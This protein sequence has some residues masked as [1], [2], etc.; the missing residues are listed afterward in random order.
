MLAESAKSQNNRNNSM[1]ISNQ[2]PR[3]SRGFGRFTTQN[4]HRISGCGNRRWW[5]AW[6]DSSGVL[7]RKVPALETNGL[8]S[9]MPCNAKLNSRKATWDS[10]TPSPKVAS[11]QSPN[12]RRTT[13]SISRIRAGIPGTSKRPSNGSI[14]SSLLPRLGR[15]QILPR[16]GSRRRLRRSPRSVIS[17]PPAGI[18][19]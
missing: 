19:I 14:W 7:H 6:R 3:Y 11:N 17:Q 12:T 9:N 10:S 15:S 4:C 13:S 2:N 5:V 1:T 16:P 18:T 8:P